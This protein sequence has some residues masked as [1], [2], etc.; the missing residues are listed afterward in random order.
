MNF[1]GI[2]SSY[3]LKDKGSYINAFLLFT[4]I[5]IKCLVPLQFV[6]DSGPYGLLGRPV[7]ELAD[8]DS[9]CALVTVPE[10]EEWVPVLVSTRNNGYVA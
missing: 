6:S 9:R 7:P 2:P 10:A 8:L 5:C 3:T 4:F 1:Y